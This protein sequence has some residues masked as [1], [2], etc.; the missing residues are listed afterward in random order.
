G[1]HGSI[2]SQAAQA[3]LVSHA[4]WGALFA[5]LFGVSFTSLTI[6]SLVMSL[7]GSLAFYALLRRVGLSPGLS[8]LGVAVLALNPYYLNLGYSFMTDV[9]F[10]ALVLLSS[11]FYFEGLRGDARWLWLGGALGAL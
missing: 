3:T 2:P 7:I 10:V 6:A 8:G 5:A 1:G 4:Y 11:L 9:S